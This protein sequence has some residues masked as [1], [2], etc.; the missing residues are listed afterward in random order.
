MK[1]KSRKDFRRKRHARIR[2]KV[3]GTAERPR[4]SIMVSNKNLYVQCIDD[5]RGVTL[6][7]ASTAGG[8]AGCNIGAAKALGRRLAE[9]A[10]GN[11]VKTVV[12]DRGGF[13]FHGRVKAIVEG[14]CEAGLVAGRNGGA[15]S[16]E[17][18]DVVSDET[19]NGKEEQ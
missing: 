4:M 8:D 16:P 9:S 15:Q 5:T 14:A 12:V 17:A 1:A 7:S 6:A 13:K 10:L 19:Q 18:G 2:R 3:R 11:G